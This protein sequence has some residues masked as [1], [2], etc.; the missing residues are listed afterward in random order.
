MHLRRLRHFTILA[1]R[2]NV[3][4]ATERLQIAQPAL[5]VSIQ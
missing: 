1:E 3:T 5:S 4:R 2:L